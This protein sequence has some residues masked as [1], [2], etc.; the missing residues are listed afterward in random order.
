MRS[1]YIFERQIYKAKSLY[2]HGQFI[3][4][5]GYNLYDPISRIAAYNP[6]TDKWRSLGDMSS[7]R[8]SAAIILK[9]NEYL[10]AGG[11]YFSG[12][13]STDKCEHKNDEELNCIQ[14]N[15]VFSTRSGESDKIT[16]NLKLTSEYYHI[17]EYKTAY[18]I[19][20]PE[21]EDSNENN[22]SN[23]NSARFKSIPI[24]KFI[25]IFMLF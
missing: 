2:N 25:T 23:S 12:S 11:D 22:D 6:K 7:A 13:K 3:V 20:D 21:N 4:F 16:E 19:K 8:S 9:N 18:C 17:F 10:I 14:Q 1:D 5:G 15:P 24:L